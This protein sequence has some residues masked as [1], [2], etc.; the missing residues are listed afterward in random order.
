M[1]TDLKILELDLTGGG[2]RRLDIVRQAQEDYLGGRGINTWLAHQYLGPEVEPLGPDNVLLISAG[3]MTGTAAPASSRI[4]LTARSPLT[5]LVGSSNM[6]GFFGASLRAAGLM[7]VAATGR[8]EKPVYALIDPDGVHLK[9]AEHLWGLD[10]WQTEDALKEELDDDKVRLLMI[11][12]AGENQ[13]PLA[14]VMGGRHAAAGRTGLGAVMGSKNLKAI[15]IRGFKNRLRLDGPAK[16]AVTRYIERIK[17]TPMFEPI[18]RHGQ[19]GYIK[20]SDDMGILST[21]NYRQGTF[22]AAE[23]VDGLKLTPHVTKRRSCHRCPVHCKADVELKG[24]SGPRPEFESLA[25]LGAKCGQTDLAAA[26]ELNEL[27]GRYGLDTMSAGSV[28]AL[29]MDLYDRGLIGPDDTDGLELTWGDAAAMKT[30]LGRIARREGFG[31]VLSGGVKRAA[32]EI[33]RGAERYAFHVKGLALSAYDPRG[34]KGTGLAYAVAGRGGDYASASAAPEY[35]WTRERARA[36]LGVAEAADRFSPQGK[37]ELVRLSLIA[38]AVV[39]SLGLCKV[40]V[41]ILL[42][43]F[44]LSLEAE[45]VSALTGL[46]ITR[47]DLARAGERIINLERLLN[48]RFGD[49]PTADR[50]PDKFLS[51]PLADGPAAGSVVELDEMLD[52][53][54]EIMGWDRTGRP[55][56]AK[57][58]ELGLD[59]TTA[60]IAPPWETKAVSDSIPVYVAV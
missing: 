30:L 52:R 55:D 53:F 31:R 44:N 29:A 24:R 49:Q 26:V 14:C 51:E 13:V 20:W 7:T 60:W 32:E 3:L 40:P 19:S 35:R 22:E 59:R 37:P 27:C 58:A 36:E 56:P 38:S 16:E 9:P 17:Q 21:R 43:D 1:T 46:E 41:L 34:V 4:H 57:L 8:S 10:V 33:G 15:A 11:G 2:H 48:I 39:D 54:Y 50:L 42:D 25:A 18:S 12:P 5:G 28:M 45:L 23:E 47:Q 6:G